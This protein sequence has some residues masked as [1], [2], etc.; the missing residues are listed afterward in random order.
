[1]S[2]REPPINIAAES[3]FTRLSGYSNSV[4]DRPME[5][6]ITSCRTG[7]TVFTF[8]AAKSSIRRVFTSA[9]PCVLQPVPLRDTVNPGKPGAVTGWRVR[10]KQ[11]R[12]AFVVA[13]LLDRLERDALAT[14]VLNDVQA[15]FHYRR[16]VMRPRSNRGCTGLT[17]SDGMSGMTLKAPGRSWDYQ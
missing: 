15:G 3:A 4:I 9:T 11:P 14:A 5:S 8:R 10:N 12:S 13:S 16:I 7:S 2:G 6:S 1:M 17:D